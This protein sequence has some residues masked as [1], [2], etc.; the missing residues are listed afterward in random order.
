MRKIVIYLLTMI[1]AVSIFLPT[2]KASAIE[3]WPTADGVSVDKTW[4]ISFNKA[5]K[6]GISLPDYIYVLDSNN[7]K[8]D[9]V[10]S[11]S[12]DSKKVM[13]KAPVK[14]Y[15][16][17]QAYT[18]IVKQ[19]L[20]AQYGKAIKTTIHK[21][22]TTTANVAFETYAKNYRIDNTS[23]AAVTA[24]V[25]TTA[26]VTV[27][28]AKGKVITAKTTMP[29]STQV[30]DAGQYAIVSYKMAPNT[31]PIATGA[32]VKVTTEQAFTV[33]KLSKGGSV[34]ID[35]ASD[36]YRTV[37]AED[38]TQKAEVSYAS[39]YGE[40]V[41]EATHTKVQQAGLNDVTL[42]YGKGQVIVS[43]EKDTPFT[44]YVPAVETQMM[45]S[46]KPALVS[47]E[48]APNTNAVVTTAE[49]VAGAFKDSTFEVIG[50]GVYHKASYTSD[51]STLGD[52]K[53]QQTVS[54]KNTEK[55]YE[56]GET[57]IQNVGNRTLTLSGA[58]KY[59][60]IQ[61]TTEKALVYFTLLPLDQIT[62][63]SR[64]SSIMRDFTIY[65]ATAEGQYKTTQFEGETVVAE[66]TTVMEMP[67]DK[68]LIYK[69]GRTIV[70]NKGS[71]TLELFGPARYVQY[72]R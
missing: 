70:E 72:S 67:L 43:N 17:N 47:Y 32:T 27:Y 28:D 30:I 37:Y 29:T 58:A 60:T 19:G 1:L 55:L 45:K 40:L 36:F 4:T 34:Q 23:K 46:A 14:G 6:S 12:D 69:K 56:A 44:V 21:R 16:T 42:L 11:R 8:M 66:R 33:A 2:M 5:V 9:V 71:T 15:A 62:V 25:G 49:P 59:T 48:L 7:N 3:E 50:S 68:V 64:E 52:Y 10:L 39:Y 41:R 18:L 22:F 38:S 20:P 57:I 53:Q 51:A 24:T 65:D 63:K 13:V 61:A 35:S 31:A 26:H 54:S